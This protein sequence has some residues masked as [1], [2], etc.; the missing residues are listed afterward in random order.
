MSKY[1]KKQIPDNILIYTHYTNTNWFIKSS[2]K[3]KGF[4]A[5]NETLKLAMEGDTLNDLIASII[6]AEMLL[7]KDLLEDY[8]HSI[9]KKEKNNVHD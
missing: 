5:T 7:M 1:K 8:I 4:V 3:T 2:S 9:H 6:D